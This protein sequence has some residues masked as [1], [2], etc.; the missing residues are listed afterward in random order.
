MKELERNV[1]RIVEKK[2]VTY[3]ND[4]VLGPGEIKKLMEICQNDPD[5]HSI[6]LTN[7]GGGGIGLATNAD[8][9]NANNEKVGSVDV[10]DFSAW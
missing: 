9:Y 2:P 6:R 3:Y 7:V 4:V 1:V 10:T 5:I 8:L